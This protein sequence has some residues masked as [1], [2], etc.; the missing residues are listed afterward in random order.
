MVA[1]IT[2]YTSL[3]ALHVLLAVLWVGGGLCLTI[4]GLRAQGSK[5]PVR[6]AGIAK[7]AEWLGLRIFVPASLLL[8]FVGAGLLET[9]YGKALWGWGQTWIILAIVGF[10]I[11]FAVGAAYLGPTAGKLGKVLDA[12]GA[13][14]PEAQALIRRILL[15]ARIDIVLLLLIVA[16]MVIKPGTAT[17]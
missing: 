15:V 5:D 4:L 13:E 9:D 12:R 8:F 3:K 11:S 6:L 2:L 16:D 14:D 7:D 17:G 10:A 1:S